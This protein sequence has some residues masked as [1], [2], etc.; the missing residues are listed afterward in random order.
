M[1]KRKFAYK[2]A[3]SN[4]GWTQTDTD[5]FNHNEPNL[6]EPGRRE[7]F[8]HQNRV[9]H[10]QIFLDGFYAIAGIGNPNGVWLAQVVMHQQF[11][12]HSHAE[13]GFWHAPHLTGFQR[14]QTN[15][16]NR[17]DLPHVLACAGI[18]NYASKIATLFQPRVSPRNL[19]VTAHPGKRSVS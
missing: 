17:P 18:F 6:L 8:L 16:T 2:D 4:D 3:D 15:A 12:D 14:L 10:L 7:L 1:K 9:V 11:A 5:S 19:V 13:T